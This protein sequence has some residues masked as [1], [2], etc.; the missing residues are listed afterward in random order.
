MRER[1]LTTNTDIM[2]EAH[3]NK[4]IKENTKLIV[5][6]EDNETDDSDDD[7]DNELNKKI[8]DTLKNNKE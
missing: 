2:N 4:I 5:P 3:K 1:A 6:S 8:V 7:V